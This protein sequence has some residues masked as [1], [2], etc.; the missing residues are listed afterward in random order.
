M[1]LT[2]ELPLLIAQI[3]SARAIMDR[4]PNCHR[5]PLR[6][7]VQDR[8]GKCFYPVSSTQWTGLLLSVSSTQW[9]GLL[10]VLVLLLVLLLLVLLLLLL[11]RSMLND[12]ASQCVRHGLCQC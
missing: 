6:P 2:V 12:H 4:E 5:E 7:R 1:L 3:Q 8:C 9:T 11:L 10:L